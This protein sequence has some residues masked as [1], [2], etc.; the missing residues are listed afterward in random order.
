M[1]NRS[2]CGEREYNRII[3]IRKRK[4]GKNSIANLEKFLDNGC[5]IEH[6]QNRENLINDCLAYCE[7]NGIKPTTL[8]QKALKD[9]FFIK[10]LQGGGWCRPETEQKMRAFIAPET[11]A[12][13][14]A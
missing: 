13:A 4:V 1:G 3:P 6:K 14:A 7:A 8:G 9:R 5:M 11:K 2:G 10:R 12:G